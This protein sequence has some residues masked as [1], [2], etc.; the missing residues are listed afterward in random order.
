MLLVH[1]SV[2][3]LCQRHFDLISGHSWIL[4]IQKLVEVQ[5]VC[6]VAL[7]TKRA[8]KKSTISDLF[9]SASKW[10]QPGIMSGLPASAQITVTSIAGIENGSRCWLYPAVRAAS[11]PLQRPSVSGSENKVGSHRCLELCLRFDDSSGLSLSFIMPT[12]SGRD[13][14]LPRGIQDPQMQVSKDATT[15]CVELIGSVDERR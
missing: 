10:T 2:F 6:C 5:N 15:I 13:G 1:C 3:E 14:K 8:E 7:S 12:S 9:L 11:L 4:S